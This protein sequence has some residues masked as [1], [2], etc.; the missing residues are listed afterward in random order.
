M[1]MKATS[2]IW[3]IG[4][5]HGRYD[6]ICDTTEYDGPE[7]GLPYGSIVK[8]TNN[9]RSVSFWNNY[10]GTLSPVDGGVNSTKGSVD[11][12]GGTKAFGW[13]NVIKSDD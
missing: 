2:D 6:W 9:Y 8:V 12:K 3:N 1:A 13:K 10:D 4:P 5:K 7:T 11:G